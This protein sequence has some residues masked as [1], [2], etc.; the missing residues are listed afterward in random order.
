MK[1]LLVLV[2]LLV[3]ENI[4]AADITKNGV[5]ISIKGE[6]V[7]GDHLKLLNAIKDHEYSL[8]IGHEFRQ[9]LRAV[10][11]GED[12]GGL[13]IT[14]IK[15][16]DFYI[17]GFI[18]I[19]S[20]GGDA[21]EAMKIGR[22]IRERKYG[23]NVGGVCFSS[24]VYILAAGLSRNAPVEFT[25]VGI[26]RPFLTAST[27][28]DI[29]IVMKQILKDSRIYFEEMNINPNLAD[30]MFS[31]EPEKMKILDKDELS[32][33]RLNQ[34]DMVYREELE[35]KLAEKYGMTRI[36]FIQ[37]QKE[38]REDT[39]K[40]C[41]TDDHLKIISDALESGNYSAFEDGSKE[42]EECIQNF[43]YKHGMFEKPIKN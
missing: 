20:Q 25:K 15:K 3:C 24:C 22:L 18:S 43:K 1:R 12:P 17:V 7:E 39:K 27:G 36:E 2:V 26:H 30:D 28:E 8:S 35:I 19:Y 14:P 41:I 38:Y 40:Y 9:I 10:E 4:I 37:A 23:V 34:V 6:V 13:K 5:G 33:Y 29:N 21:S 42:L 31:I 16:E 11:R 32:L